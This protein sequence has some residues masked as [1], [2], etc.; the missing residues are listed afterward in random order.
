METK[1][2]KIEVPNGYEI[3]KEK[4]TFENIVF[5]KADDIVIKWNKNC[6]GVEI[7]TD[8]EHFILDGD[9]DYCMNWDDAMRFFNKKSRNR[10]WNLPTVKQ[11]QVIHNY[12]DKINTIIEENDGSKLID[13]YYW[14]CENIDV[15]LSQNV[16][17][18]RGYIY[19]DNKGNNNYVRAVSA[20]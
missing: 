12:F 13:A 4:S 17:M 18:Y 7:K 1:T 16:N 6:F 11:L 5:K 3:D 20:L 15:F 2:L 8:D 19:S 9:P 14:S 10:I